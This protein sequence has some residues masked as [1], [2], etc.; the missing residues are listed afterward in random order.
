MKNE[1]GKEKN[2][3]LTIEQIPYEQLEREAR[4][5]ALA[6]GE[7]LEMLI[8]MDRITNTGSDPEEGVVTVSISQRHYSLLREAAE[9]S[10][11]EVEETA[12]IIIGLSAEMLP[13][14]PLSRE[15]FDAVVEAWEGVDSPGGE[16]Q[17]RARRGRN[18]LEKPSP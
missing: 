17:D 18:S 10:G 6:P 3:T 7:Y 11:F 2:V 13:E 1:N 5:R 8:E 14:R 12:E 4:K 16:K 15:K 9:E